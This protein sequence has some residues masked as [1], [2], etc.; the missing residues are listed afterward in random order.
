M[1]RIISRT[2]ARD[3]AEEVQEEEQVVAAGELASSQNADEVTGMGG[4]EGGGVE[5]GTEDASIDLTADISPIQT[6]LQRPYT[7]IR[8]RTLKTTHPQPMH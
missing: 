3:D 5:E 4:Q 1:S 2:E 7:R 8:E 6:L